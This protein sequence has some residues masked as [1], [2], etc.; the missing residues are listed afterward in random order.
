MIWFIII[1][2][3]GLFLGMLYYGQKQR[4]ELDKMEK[5]ILD[6]KKVIEQKE[7]D[8]IDN[9]NAG[10]I[11]NKEQVEDIK[12]NFAQ[13]RNR[14]EIQKK[15]VKQRETIIQRKED[16]CKEQL[17]KIAIQY[18]KEKVRFEKEMREMSQAKHNAQAG[19]KRLKNKINR[20]QI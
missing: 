10:W 3:I 11:I 2:F 20:N 12:K 14:I 9:I 5:E 7:Q 6:L 16:A 4:K 19:Y 13:E 8:R 17:Q 18:K 15:Q 1:L